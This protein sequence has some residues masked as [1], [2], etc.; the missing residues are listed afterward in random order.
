MLA[1][2]IA[3][4]TWQLIPV[5]ILVSIAVFLSFALFRAIRCW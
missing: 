3:Q 5:L 1:R 2:Y 4:R